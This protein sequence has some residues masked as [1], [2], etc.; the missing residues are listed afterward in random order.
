MDR[1]GAKRQRISYPP[2]KQESVPFKLF[3]AD[4]EEVV[5]QSK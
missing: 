1:I 5:A 4:I 2:G 3:E